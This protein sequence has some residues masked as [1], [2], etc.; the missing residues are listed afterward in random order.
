V[1]HLRWIPY[2]LMPPQETE[3][4][5]LS[6]KLLHQLRSIEHHG[7]QFFITLDESWFY[8]LTDHEQTWFRIEEQPPERPTHIIQDPKMMLTIA[9]NPLGFHLLGALP[10][11]D[12]FNAE[13]YRVNIPTELLPV[14]PQVDGRR[15]VIL[16]DNARPR[17]TRKYRA[18]GEENRLR[19]AVHPPYPPDLAPSHFFLFG[20]IKHCLQ[21]IAFSFRENLLAAIHEIIGAIPRPT[22]ENVF[23]HW[24]ERPEWVSQNDD[25]D[26]PQAKSW[27]I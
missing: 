11:G 15:P 20:Y 12:T 10:K 26:C 23:R 2:T 21:G 9:W 22:L 3:C 17:T 8:L 19:L 16:A 6:I 25:D 7:W 5:T 24:M 14:R 4:L 13:Y 18:F 27:L 1:K